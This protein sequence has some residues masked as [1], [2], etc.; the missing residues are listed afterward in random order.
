KITLFFLLV[1]NLLICFAQEPNLGLKFTPAD[2]LQGIPL[3]STPYSGTELPS[4]FD[5]SNNLPPAGNQGN[6]N[7]CVAWAVGYA[8]KSYQE[9]KEEESSYLV[10]GQLNNDALFSPSFIYNQINNGVD[11]GSFFTD[12]LNILSQQGCLKWADMP[13]NEMDYLTQPSTLQ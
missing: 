3:A 4:S 10:N 7:S 13:Y 1:C 6:Q 9:K 2:Q 11:G 5:L 8:Y 12:A